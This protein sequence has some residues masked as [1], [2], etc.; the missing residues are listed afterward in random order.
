MKIYF[1][2]IEN[3]SIEGTYIPKSTENPYYRQF[4]E[5]LKNGEAKLIPYTAPKASWDEVKSKRDQ[6]L[7]ETDWVGLK[8]VTVTNEKAWLKY[9]Q[10]LR[11]IPQKFSDPSK[12][13][14]PT[15]PE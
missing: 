7:R 1:D 5:E 8:D 10:D 6:L 3:I 13:V 9:R 14:W 12:V 15:K 11:D 2:Y 4:L